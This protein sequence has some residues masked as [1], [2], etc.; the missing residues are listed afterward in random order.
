MRTGKKGGKERN[1]GWLAVWGHTK[2]KRK[3]RE[4]KDACSSFFWG[5]GNY[6]APS[7]EL[8]PDSVRNHLVVMHIGAN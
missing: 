4:E 8:F 2:R 3:K 6:F 7:Q 5:N 1:K